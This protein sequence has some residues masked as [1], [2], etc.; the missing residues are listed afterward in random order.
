MKKH[1]EGDSDFILLV[2]N[3]IFYLD[4][5]FLFQALPLDSKRQFIIRLFLFRL[6]PVYNL[7]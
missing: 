3:L 1:R 4:S 2:K 6:W 7:Y 5:D